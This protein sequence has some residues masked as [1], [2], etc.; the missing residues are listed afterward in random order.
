M[1]RVWSRRRSIGI[2]ALTSSHGPSCGFIVHAYM[3]TEPPL[4]LEVDPGLHPFG[5][6]LPA[7]DE[8][9]Q[10]LPRERKCYSFAPTI[11]SRGIG[12]HTFHGEPTERTCTF[13]ALI[14]DFLGNDGH[15]GNS[16]SQRSVEISRTYP[17]AALQQI[18]S[19]EGPTTR[20]QAKAAAA[21]QTA[22]PSRGADDQHPEDWNSDST[23][24]SPQ[25][26]PRSTPPGSPR[27]RE[28]S[29][30]PAG[31][32]VPVMMAERGDEDDPQVLK[33]QLALR[34]QQIA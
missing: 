29:S 28:F 25:A 17:P 24:D 20:R 1:L 6:S 16:R 5:I 34:D 19:R 32:A 23:P 3:G 4:T 12:I 10:T 18:V 30:R 31:G 33:E 14:E 15:T 22:T 13:K 21:L 7:E 8:L 9:D 2:A 26:S 11:G 27:S